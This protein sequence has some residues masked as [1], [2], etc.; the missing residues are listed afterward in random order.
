MDHIVMRN[1]NTKHSRGFGCGLYP[2]V[3][4]VGTAVATRPHEVDGRVVEPGRAVT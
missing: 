1:L 2:T 4:E 3:E